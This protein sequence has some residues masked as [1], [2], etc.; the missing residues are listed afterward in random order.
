[1]GLRRFICGVVGKKALPKSNP[2]LVVVLRYNV[3]I[4]DINAMAELFNI[5]TCLN[6]RGTTF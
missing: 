1:M 5:K 4:Y 2:R 3:M 6:A